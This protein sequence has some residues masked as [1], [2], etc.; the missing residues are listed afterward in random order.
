MAVLF[1]T[2]RTEGT[3]MG[4]SS[5]EWGISRLLCGCWFMAPSCLGLKLLIY[6]LEFVSF[7][8]L[9]RAMREDLA[10]ALSVLLPHRAWGSPFPSPGVLP[11]R[12]CDYRAAAP[13][14]WLLRGGGG[15]WGTSCAF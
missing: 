8:S 11:G 14:L 1:F 10:E 5:L 15:A 6:T 3:G 7:K 9:C 4:F 2:F 12:G 13:A